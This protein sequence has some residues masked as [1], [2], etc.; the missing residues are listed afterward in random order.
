[1]AARRGRLDAVGGPCAVG[2]RGLAY[3]FTSGAYRAWI[4]DEVGAAN[5]G[6]VFLRGTRIS[7]LGSFIGLVSLGAWSLKAAVIVGG[8]ITIACGLAC[9]DTAGE[10]SG[11]HE[12]GLT[13]HPRALALAS[14]APPRPRR[15][16]ERSPSELLA[17]G[18]EA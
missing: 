11:L 7:F 4:T 3:T 12:R 14:L 8:V 18:R 17:E 1:M 15:R 5:V 16:G 6:V 2:G 10:L 13:V 9:A